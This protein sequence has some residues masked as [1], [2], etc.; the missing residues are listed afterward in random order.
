MAHRDTQE[1]GHNS[2]QLAYYENRRPRAN[3]RIAVRSTPYIANHIEKFVA[4][5]GISREQS[6]LDIGC[7]MGK[8]TIPLAQQGYKLEGLDL[9]QKLLDQLQNNAAERAQIITHCGDILRP[10]PTLAGR[11]D[12][13]IGFFVLHHLIDLEETFRRCAQLLRPG[14]RITFLEPNPYCPLYYAQITFSPT[15]SWKAEKGILNLTPSRMS[16]AVGAAGF[17]DFHLERFGILPPI[18]R[19][20]TSGLRFEQAFEKGHFVRPISAFQLLRAKLE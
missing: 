4:F 20:T 2:Y 18:L 16:Q 5:S 3:H 14:G 13:V 8:Y 1:E 6:V 19:N 7:G 10:D 9:S 11:F 17:S 12:H 15:M